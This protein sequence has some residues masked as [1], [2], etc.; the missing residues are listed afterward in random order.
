M[1]RFYYLIFDFQ[2]SDKDM[3]GIHSS[4]QL[5][6][7]RLAAGSPLSGDSLKHQK[8]ANA[9]ISFPSKVQNIIDPSL[10]LLIQIENTS[11][12]GSASKTKRYEMS[13]SQ[14]G[15]DKPT[16]KKKVE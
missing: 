5:A 10:T 4:I 1:E 13:T 16:K 3:S 12:N 9:L 7:V 6:V 11:L 2:G 15:I 8:P 14:I